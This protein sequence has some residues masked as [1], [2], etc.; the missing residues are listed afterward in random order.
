V[1]NHAY[2]FDGVNDKITTTG[3]EDDMAFIHNTGVFTVSA[4]I[5]INNL[6]GRNTIVGN[7]ITSTQKGFFF[8]YDNYSSTYNHQ[9]RFASQ[10]AK[11][12]VYN[13]VVGGVRTINDNAWHHVV[14]VGDGS[15]I[16][17]Y[18]DGYQDGYSTEILYYGDGTNASL[19]LTIGNPNHATLTFMNGGIDEVQIWDRALSDAEI[20][21]LAN[22]KTLEEI[23]F[24]LQPSEK[25]RYGYQGQ[26]A[27]RDE[28]TGWNHFEL[29]EYDPVVGRWTSMDPAAQYCSP[30]VGMG[31]NPTIG[32]DPD[33]AVTFDQ[34]INSKGEIVYDNGVNNGNVFFVNE[35]YNKKIETLEQLKANST[36]V[37]KDWIWQENSRISVIDYVGLQ[38]GIAYPGVDFGMKS[39]WKLVEKPTHNGL[40][41]L[42]SV[43]YG[44]ENGKAY[45]KRSDRTRG[46][47]II[48]NAGKKDSFLGN[49]YN[50]RSI[51]SHEGYHFVQRDQIKGDRMY[52]TTLKEARNWVERG[53][54]KYQRNN[55]W[56]KMVNFQAPNWPNAKVTKEQWAENYIR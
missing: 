39:N 16:R 34:G 6:D 37:M 23:D 44:M 25:Y 17:L 29:R 45:V 13:E 7:T 31:N 46:L 15:T 28:E 33:G 48:Y 1:S 43:S 47:D 54:I 38:S 26:F 40:A 14:A 4:F 10:V 2:L 22:E 18:V 51:L 9:L 32:I 55:K 12:G 19:P 52:F 3:T 20:R 41:A 5:K 11:S 21:L 27:E 8:I 35:G 24:V 50:L 56:W 42:G 36:Q 53:A 30:Y 49:I